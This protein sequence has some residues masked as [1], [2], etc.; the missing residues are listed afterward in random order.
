LFK[1]LIPLK[2][3][4]GGLATTEVLADAELFDLMVKSGCKFLL[5]GFESINQPS[6]NSIAKGFNRDDDYKTIIQQLH[7]A[8]ISVQGCFVFGFDHDDK[9]IFQSTVERVQDLKID[10][11]RYSIYTPYPGTRLFNRLVAEDRIVSYDWN[12][13]DT[14]HVVYQPKQMSCQELYD[15][16]RHAYKTTFKFG[17][18]IKRVASLNVSCPINLVG[19]LA[20]KLFV[21]RLYSEERFIL[22]YSAYPKKTT[23]IVTREDFAS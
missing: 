4:W 6:L 9:D 11:P 23:D 18:I 13:Y 21:K 8:N 10:I 22:P 17:N 5:I 12:D 16:F 19:N 15:G 14:M 7:K 2:K 3:N 1:A 20:Y